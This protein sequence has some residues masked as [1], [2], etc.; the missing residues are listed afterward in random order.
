MVEKLDNWTCS[1]ADMIMLG[2]KEKELSK[3][4]RGQYLKQS[5][6]SLIEVQLR[7]GPAE[8]PRLIYSRDPAN[9]EMQPGKLCNLDNQ[10]SV[11]ANRTLDG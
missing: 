10:K 8:R 11:D 6:L 4:R 1:A 3:S 7:G 5:L 9:W 2:W